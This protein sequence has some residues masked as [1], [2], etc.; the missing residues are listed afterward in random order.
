MFGVATSGVVLATFQAAVDA[1][2]ELFVIKDCC[3]DSDAELHRV[4]LDNHF[5]RYAGVL[6]ADEFQELLRSERT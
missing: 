1:D 4:L 2:Y 5:P 3:A 6:D